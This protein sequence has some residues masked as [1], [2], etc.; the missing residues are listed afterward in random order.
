MSRHVTRTSQHYQQVSAGACSPLC[1][2][3]PSEEILSKHR[4][5]SS[6]QIQER[7]T[8]I[9]PQSEDAILFTCCVWHA[10]VVPNR[11][12][13]EEAALATVHYRM[14]IERNFCNYKGQRG[15]FSL[16]SARAIAHAALKALYDI[17]FE[18]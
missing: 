11:Q 1:C 14:M 2:G 13:P 12:L 15:M 5:L 17:Q 8:L 9:G 3:I 7:V 18:D 10:Q 6:W 16:Q 4:P